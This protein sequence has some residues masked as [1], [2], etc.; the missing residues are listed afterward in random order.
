MA[1]AREPSSTLLMHPTRRALLEALRATP[2]ATRADLARHLQ[3]APT[4][5]A[6]HLAQ[7]AW[8]GHVV[9]VRTPRGVGHY[10]NGTAPPRDA[11]GTAPAPGATAARL[12]RCL[13]QGGAR[14]L[15][16][17]AALAGVSEKAAYWHLARLERANLVRAG[18]EGRAKV[19]WRDG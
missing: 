5:V 12:L 1:E 13:Q 15:A 17:V 19:Y 11:R 16:D 8:A 7:L 14:S 9:A 6:H 10:L 3:L 2:G 4:T 18:F